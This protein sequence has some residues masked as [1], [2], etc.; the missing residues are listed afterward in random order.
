M[1]E[2]FYLDWALQPGPVALTGPEA[3][4]LV[5]VCRLRPGDELRLFNGD[6][7]EY[8][9]RIV[10]AT[11]RA[12]NL[13]VFDVSRPRRELPFRLEVAAPIPKGDRSQV[14]IEKLTELG[15]TTFIPLACQRSIVHPREARYEK[16]ARY[17]IEAS[18]QCGR[19]VLMNV[20]TLADWE[21]YCT[22]GGTEKLRVLA[23]P[24][25]RQEAAGREN[26]I[27][28]LG[29]L[30]RGRA[31]LRLAVGPEGGFTETEIAA[32][33]AAGWLTIDLGRCILRIETAALA[34]AVIGNLI[35]ADFESIA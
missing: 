6:G 3:H 28:R 27:G 35:A 5:N 32:A 24:D 19:N 30:M 1:S 18:K 9:T 2:R 11:R 34:L 21:T 13:E 25:P 10:A 15:V 23:H 4:H 29:E 33:R 22:A 26:I 12:V 31:E 20:G 16:F 17:V 14:L 7:H 8:A